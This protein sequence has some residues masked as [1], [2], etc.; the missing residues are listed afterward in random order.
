MADNCKVTPAYTLLKSRES[1]LQWIKKSII[2]RLL[3]FPYS[4]KNLI[5]SIYFPSEWLWSWCIRSSI[6]RSLL[7]D[8]STSILELIADLHRTP[9]VSCYL[10]FVV[11]AARDCAAP[12]FPGGGRN[13]FLM[14][15]YFRFPTAAAETEMRTQTHVYLRDMVVM[16]HRQIIFASSD[17]HFILVR[18]Q[19]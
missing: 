5:S 9:F 2:V 17:R 16:S 7:G 14:R 11:S 3:T 15:F 1:Q 8:L 6:T 10:W 12:S 13:C 19:F 4:I 18:W